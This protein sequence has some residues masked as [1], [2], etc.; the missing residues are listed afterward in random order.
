MTTED[1]GS[2]SLRNQWGRRNEWPRWAVVVAASCLAACGD[3][4]TEPP[5]TEPPAN[6]APEA[7]GSIPDQVLTRGGIA[8]TVDVAGNFMDPDGGAL[9]YAVTSSNTGVVRASVSGSVVTLEP[10]APG[11]AMVTV[12]A[13]DSGG[14]TAS[15]SFAVTVTASPDLVA[16]VSPDSVAVAPG[17]EVEYEAS[18]RN[19]GDTVSVATRV[20]AFLSAD[21]VITTSDEMVGEASDV[22]ALGPG[23]STSRT[24]SYAVGS[25]ASPGTVVYLGECV[26]PVDGESDADNNCSSALKVTIAS[27]D[28][29]A[30]MSPDSVAVAPGGSFEYVVLVRNRGNG[31]AGA[32]QV[33]TFSSEDSVVTTSDEVVGEASDVPALGPGETASRAASMTVSS[34]VSPGTVVYVGECVD[35]VEDESDTSNNCSVPI[36][37]MVTGQPDLVATVSLDSVSV[38]PGS[39]FEYEVEVLNRGAAAAPATRVRTF[40]SEDSVVTRLD[41]IVGD[42]SRVPGLGPG[43]SV[44]G[45]ASIT[46]SSSASPGTVVYLGECVDPVEGEPDTDNNCSSAIKLTIVTTGSVQPAESPF[47][48]RSGGPNSRVPEAAHEAV[49]RLAGKIKFQPAARRSRPGAGSACGGSSSPGTGASSRPALCLSAGDFVQAGSGPPK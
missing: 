5:P 22:P 36:K 31:A 42:A 26:D 16:S 7:R 15:L 14:L 2:I 28:L 27:P 49:V 41:K 1:A 35:P 48:G 34:S 19:Q 21:S 4:G 20:R 45:R 9:T 47:A 46:A 40:A 10:V 3:S 13:R 17:G 44:R 25:S 39:S 33:R 11:T 29:V 23:E 6:R 24:I 18:V 43:E 8:A 12:T 30:S 37:V 32:T 38:A